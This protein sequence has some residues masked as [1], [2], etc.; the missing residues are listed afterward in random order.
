MKLN[1]KLE[2]DSPAERRTRTDLL[3]LA[4][5]HDLQ[6]WLF[7]DT[8]IIDETARPHSHPVLTLNVNYEQN[9]YFLLASFVHEQLH[10]FEE[11]RKEI[12]DRAIEATR[13]SYPE[14]ISSRPEGSGDERSTRLHLLVC[15]LEYQILKVLIGAAAAQQ[16]ILELSHHHYRWIY[17]TVLRDEKKIERVVREFAFFPDGLRAQFY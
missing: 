10:W 12:R 7:T 14:V 9:E 5:L 1:L 16:T 4:Q 2:H 17:A 11:E 13:D 6:P 15:Y 8:I 3:E